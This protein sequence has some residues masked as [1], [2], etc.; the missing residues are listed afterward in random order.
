M[1]ARHVNKSLRTIDENTW[2]VNERFLLTRQRQQ[3]EKEAGSHAWKDGEG[4]SYALTEPTEPLPPPHEIEKPVPFP[5]VYD[6]GGLTIYSGHAAW[7]IGNAFLKIIVPDSPLATQEHVTLQTLSTETFSFAIPKVLFHGE[8][9]GRYHI[10]LTEIPGKNLIEAWWDMSESDRQ[11]CVQ[12]VADA[13]KEMAAWRQ[14]TLICGL[15]GKQLSENGFDT[16]ADDDDPNFS[17]EFLHERCAELGMTCSSPFVF[18]HCDLNPGNIIWNGVGGRLG[19]I[20]WE[21]AGF[22]PREWIRTKFIVAPGMSL[23]RL[24]LPEENFQWAQRMFDRLGEE[25]FA[26]VSDTYVIDR[27]QRRAQFGG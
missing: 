14:N 20:D 11:T 1:A 9:A 16:Q 22:V 18:Y 19:V 3:T 23:D 17:P 8:W 2:A 27:K 24:D 26:E 5:L 10:V 25:G 15:D 12:R 4:W 13:C 7:K 21:R 6:A